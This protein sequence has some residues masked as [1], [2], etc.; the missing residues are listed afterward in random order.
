MKKIYLILS[1][2]FPSYVSAP[3]GAFIKAPGWHN[4][5]PGFIIEYSL[6]LPRAHANSNWS[7]ESSKNWKLQRKM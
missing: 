6:Q 7:L 2:L 3:H 5:Q 4:S 1:N